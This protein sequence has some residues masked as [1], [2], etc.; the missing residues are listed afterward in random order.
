MIN[1][2]E[3]N[4]ASEYIATDQ[5]LYQNEQ[6]QKLKEHAAIIEDL[7]KRNPFW[8]IYDLIKN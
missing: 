3:E 6:F 1:S 7:T 2:Y 8:F 4:V 5:L